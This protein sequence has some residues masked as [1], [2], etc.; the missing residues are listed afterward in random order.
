MSSLSLL[1]E[2]TSSVVTGLNP[3]RCACIQWRH[4]AKTRHG[5]ACNANAPPPPIQTPQMPDL[6]LKFLSVGTGIAARGIAVRA[7]E[8]SPPG[9]FW[10]GGFKSDMK[11]TKAQALDQWAREHGR[12]MTRFDYSGHG[13]SEGDFTDGTIG[14]WLE[15]SL[16]V[17]DACCRGPQVVIGSSMGGWLALLLARELARRAQTDPGSGLARADRARGGLYRRTDVEAL[18]AGD[19]ARDRADRRVVAPVAIFRGAL[20]HHPRPDRGG[21]RAPPARQHDRNRLSGPHPSGRAGSG[22]AVAAR[23]R[24][25]LPVCPA[26]MSCSLWSRTETIACRG[27]KTS[28]G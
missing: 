17:F 26:T 18:P 21:P 12:A 22:R 16:A 15:E 1:T 10:L 14:R 11:G 27:P 28:S 3:A 9:L 20:S 13:E 19:Q 6:C 2:L 7:R 25:R 5:P 24:A 23:G 8:G 4:A